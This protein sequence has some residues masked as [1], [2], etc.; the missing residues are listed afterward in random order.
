MT[1]P[2]PSPHGPIGLAINDAPAPGGWASLGAMAGDAEALGAGTIWVTD[3]LFWHTPSADVTAALTLV[4]MATT[5]C[6]VGPLVLQLPLHVPARVAKAMSFI[7]HLTGGRV[8]VGVGVGESEA[9]YVA[10]G[11]GDRFR[12]RGRLLDDGIAE[13]RQ[14]WSGDGDLTM[15]PVRNLPVWVGGRSE[16]AR[17]RAATTAEGWIPYLVRLPWFQEQQGLLTA[18]LDAAGRDPAQF[19]RGVALV[20]AVDDVEPDGDP[21]GWLS[22][23]YA[24]PPKA[25]EHV[26][27]R[28]SAREVADEI[29]QYRAV[30]ADHVTL[31][32]ASSRPLDHLAPVMD[33]LGPL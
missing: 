16:R 9:E 3:H 6:A 33:A 25:F 20:V 8:V 18:D 4:A 5:T 11:L 26:L 21:L 31:L 27:V 2:S 30:G 17:R 19:T 29:Q 22:R 7:D 23:L 15:A 32:V 24:L 10:A 12:H 14:A 1:V 13:L 28:G